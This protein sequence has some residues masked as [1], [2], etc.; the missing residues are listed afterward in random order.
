[1]TVRRA[2]AGLSGN[3]YADFLAEHARLKDDL[4]PR[5]HSRHALEI[6]TITPNGMALG[7]ETCIVS[8]FFKAAVQR[9]VESALVYESQLNS[10]TTSSVRITS[11]RHVGLQARL[12]ASERIRLTLEA[13]E[14]AM[15][16]A[17]ASFARI[18]AE[19]KAPH[20]FAGATIDAVNGP[21][22]QA[23]V[24]GK[25]GP[26]GVGVLGAYDVG[27]DHSDRRGR[28]TTLNVATSYTQD[29]LVALLQVNDGG[30]QLQVDLTQ[31]VSPAVMIT[32]RFVLNRRQEKPTMR[33]LGTYAPRATE[34]V[35]GSI[36]SDGILIGAFEWRT[37]KHLK[38]R[39]SA[40]MD[41]RHYDSDS[42]SLGVSIELG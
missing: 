14:T 26:V 39:V 20:V 28:L 9:R 7:L 25:V 17:P 4:E 33:L 10:I 18:G 35:A 22:F 27:L 5:K 40:Q 38:T 37:S 41:L 19:Y 32:S 42:H 31:T 13:Q 3:L 16:K 36:G 1:M 8:S 34:T 15:E 12:Q 11:S 23:T 29:D 2:T 21:T 30:R 24:G 6:N